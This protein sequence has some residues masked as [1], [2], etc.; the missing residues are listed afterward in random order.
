MNKEIKA[1]VITPNSYSSDKSYPVVYLLHGYSGNYKSWLDG[2]PQIEELAEQYQL[3]IV[4]PDGNFDSWYWDSP[5]DPTSKYETYITQELIP[6]VDTNYRTIASKEGRAIS[7][8]S[9]GGHG[10]LYLGIRHQ[11]IF[12]TAGS[13]SG[14]VDI[15]SF[16]E[17]WNMK[18]YLG[19]KSA[20][21]ERWREYSVMGQL[22]LLSR[23]N[24]PLVIHCGIGDFFYQVNL[25]LHEELTYLNIPHTFTSNPG[26][27]NW[28]YWKESV[29]Y[30]LLYFHNFFQ[31]GD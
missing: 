12:G 8:L 16:P 17:N 28:D 15:G 10:A 25:K 22:H 20:F 29:Q 27:H 21:P 11:D 1:L 13:Q 14:G 23:D 6:Y 2:A 5:E 24:L 19:E 4:T 18:K 31:R 30:Q 7:G 26:A 3:I 9:M